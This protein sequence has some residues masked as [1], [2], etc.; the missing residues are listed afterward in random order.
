MAFWNRGETAE[1]ESSTDAGEFNRAR[2][3]ALSQAAVDQIEILPEASLAEEE[4]WT[5]TPAPSRVRF[6]AAEVGQIVSTSAPGPVSLD[7]G[8]IERKMDERFERLEATL[9][10]MEA[11]M[12]EGGVMAAPGDTLV[13][14]DGS[15]T[16]GADGE[17]ADVLEEIESSQES[18]LDMYE[19]NALDLNPFLS[20]GAGT[21]ALGGPN[22][23]TT[24]LVALL[25]DHLSGAD[26]VAFLDKAEKGGVLSKSEAS[27]IS[28]IVSLAN[29]GA[30]SEVEGRHLPHRALLTFSAMLTSWRRG[31]T[32][33]A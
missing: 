9:S 1:E 29:P 8:D 21:S 32:E 16:L 22:V 20:P 6:E 24:Q 27:E 13:T 33:G 19:I 5:L 3:E 11:R 30:A 15:A 10:M 7:T 28:G 25:L 12:M 2:L 4:A 26:A 31:R 18:L 14:S 17:Y 23:A